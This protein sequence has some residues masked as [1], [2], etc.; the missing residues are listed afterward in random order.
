[1]DFFTRVA[2][3][4]AGDLDRVDQIIGEALQSQI[5]LTREVARH[6]EAASG[7]RL[8]P[9]LTLLAARTGGGPSDRVC[10]AAAFAEL[11]HIASLLHDDVIDAAS[12][13]RGQ[14]T[15]NKRWG[16]DVAILMAD[17]TYS[18][19]WEIAH[20]HLPT[21][22][23]A[24][25]CRVAAGMCDGEMFQIETRNR[26]LSEA[27]H[28]FIIRCKTA[29]LFSV[30]AKTGAALGGMPEAA[31]AALERYGMEFGLAFQI[32]DDILDFTADP[33]VLGKEIGTDI[34]CGRQTLPVIRALEKADRKDREFLLAALNNGSAP[35]VILECVQ[36]YGGI[37]YALDAARA[38]A[39]DAR[40]ALDGLP[41]I[42]ARQFLIELTE[43]V[44]NRAY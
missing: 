5:G 1:M 4:L 11:L 12:L 17:Y 8:R 41:D 44:V 20:T 43:L 35:Q 29:G 21:D 40:Q 13:R 34:A 22:L 26:L 3:Y 23:M 33:R 7:K 30:C 19:A 37:A 25:F 42:P 6:I 31:V 32:T 15:V 18:R 16:N 10:H 14:P 38:H 2:E 27:D 39:Q 28:L 36:K 9:I 24:A